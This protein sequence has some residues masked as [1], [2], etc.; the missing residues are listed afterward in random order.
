MR[1]MNLL[2]SRLSPYLLAGQLSAASPRCLKQI[3]T[4]KGAGVCKATSDGHMDVRGTQVTS[5]LA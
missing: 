1:N 2:S 5:R 4:R 3:D